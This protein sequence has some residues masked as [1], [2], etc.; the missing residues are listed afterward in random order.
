M[1]N[2]VSIQH[3]DH[4]DRPCKNHKSTSWWTRKPRNEGATI[5][6]RVRPSNA[7]DDAAFLHL[8]CL[9]G[10]NIPGDFSFSAWE[11]QQGFW[12]LHST[13]KLVSIQSIHFQQHQTE[14]AE[15]KHIG[16]IMK[17]LSSNELLLD[18]HNAFRFKNGVAKLAA[19]KLFWPQNLGTWPF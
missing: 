1:Q 10:P 13:W 9:K 19:S 11:I 18:H 12:F 8:W 7:C 15:V 4:V 14:W 17:Y 3:W 16:N 6:L 5:S 2:D